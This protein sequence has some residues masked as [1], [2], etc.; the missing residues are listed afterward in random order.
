[1][2][3]YLFVFCME[4]LSRMLKPLKDHGNFRQNPNCVSLNITHLIFADDL[5]LFAKGN[6]SSVKILLDKFDLFSCTSGLIPN[7]SK[8]AIY[9]AGVSD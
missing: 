7:K 2:S 4:Y 9:F 3:P 5:L 6:M 1:M 8:S